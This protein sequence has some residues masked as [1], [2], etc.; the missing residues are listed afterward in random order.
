MSKKIEFPKSP[1]RTGPRHKHG[2][3]YLDGNAKCIVTS[4]DLGAFMSIKCVEWYERKGEPV[5]EGTPTY[6]ECE[7][8]YERQKKEAPQ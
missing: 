7:A 3:L 1:V 2:N 6:D 8:E 5:P 4:R